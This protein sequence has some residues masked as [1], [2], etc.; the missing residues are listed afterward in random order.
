VKAV[1]LTTVFGLVASVSLLSAQEVVSLRVAGRANAFPWITA[2]RSLVAVVWGATSSDGAA[3]VYLAI[4][5]DAGRTFGVPVRVNDQPGAARVGGELPPRV[6]LVA[7]DDDLVIVVT[8]GSK[9]GTTDIRV[10]SSVD[11]GR[12][13]AA[14]RALNTAGVGGDRGWHATAVD[15]HGNVHA[16]W[17]DHRALAALP[18][19]GHD[20]RA[21]GADMAQFSSLYYASVGTSPAPGASAPQAGTEREL[22]NGVCYCCKTAMVTG[23][24]GTI[25][26]AWRHVYPGNM[27]DIAMTVSRDGGKSFQPPV[28]V[29]ADNWQ[30]AGCP[31]DGPA[32][33]V[34]SDG[35]V[36]LVWPTVLREVEPEDRMRGAIF[37]AS[38]R[39]GRRFTHRIEV[40][41]PGTL[42]PSHPQIASDDAGGF[43]VAWDEVRVGI[44]R[45]F[46]RRLRFNAGGNPMFGEAREVD[47]QGGAYP[48]IAATT[49]GVF[50]AWTHG[51]RADS[52]IRVK[53]L[54]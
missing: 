30:L 2:E 42:K 34:G 10:S 31:D 45:A 15:R 44:R 12:S 53:R 5:R 11:G 52:E 35:T 50:V 14:S 47:T 46:T 19:T 3:D 28:R 49:R 32:A 18:K 17:L 4:S 38:T 54:E 26:A 22:T 40:P 25:Y 6:S 13:F 27:R 36:H 23:P 33:A 8:W 39:D 29:S 37:Y 7:S 43:I 51:T 48:V 21:G 41:T 16:V 20:H 1:R 24:D 9:S